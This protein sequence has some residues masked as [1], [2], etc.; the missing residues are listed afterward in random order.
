MSPAGFEPEIPA[1]GRQQ[2]NALGRAAT[3]IG[4]IHQF[5]TLR[6]KY[7]IIK[8]IR[9]TKS[10]ISMREFQSE[11]LDQTTGGNTVS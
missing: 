1:G 9:D 8:I 3:G 6:C 4:I 2:T 7:C 10:Q 5:I 11:A